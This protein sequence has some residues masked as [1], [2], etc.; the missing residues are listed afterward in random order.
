VSAPFDQY[1]Q[2]DSY[3]EALD[4]GLSASGESQDFFLHGRVLWLKRR[5]DE[6]G[7]SAGR[8][9]DFGCGAGSATPVLN[10]ILAA[11]DITGLDDSVMQIAL[12]RELHPDA[13][14]FSTREY[15]PAGRCD[16]VYS[17]GVFHHIPPA[18]RPA[19]I[20]TIYQSLSPG[21]LLALWEN[22]PWNPG[23]RY[24]MSRIPFD[25]DAVTLNPLETRA[26]L[27]AG[28][29]QVLRSD[30]LFYFPRSLRR[31]RALEPYL[32]RLPLG[33]QYLTLGRR[34]ADP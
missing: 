33:A 24:V 5:L 29:F 9:L 27:R 15:T 3:R 12:A 7:R 11:R 14:F 16:L 28:G 10:A 22:N 6:M 18:Q 13:T 4:R 34:P 30:F 23:T 25:R 32:V 1:A 2:I 8:V 26:L 17:N 19:A 31:L 21:G 20:Q